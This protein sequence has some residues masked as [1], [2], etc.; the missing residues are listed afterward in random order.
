MSNPIDVDPTQSPALCV[1]GDFAWDVLVKTD[2][3]LQRGGDTFGDVRL[4]PGGSGANVAVWAQ[5]SGLNS[6]FVGKIGSD[7]LGELAVEDLDAEHVA[8]SLALSSTRR[9][10]SVAVLLD[11]EGERSM[12]S[13]FGADFYLLP[14]EVPV[15]VIAAAQHLHL[16]AW[17]LFNDPPRSAALLAARVARDSEVTLSLDPASFQILGDFGADAFIELTAPLGVDVVLPNFEEGQVLTGHSE[18][19]KIAAALADAYPGALVVLK[20]D[21]DGALIRD[22]DAVVH[23][24]AAPGDL[25]DATGA[26]DSFA[27]AFLSRWLRGVSPVAS[28]EFA[29]RVAAWVIGHRGARPA[30]PRELVSG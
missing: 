16:T 13:G 22:G 19:N 10:G 21:A 17:A 6:H 5:R 30:C 29:A 2:T 20:L 15:D 9:T 23:I 26:G 11:H 24:P 25:I 1:V 3:E 14:D 7:R 28:A 4:T 27:G 12:V 18:P 8:H